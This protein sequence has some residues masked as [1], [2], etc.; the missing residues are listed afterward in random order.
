MDPKQA[1][2]HYVSGAIERGESTAIV[3]VEHVN[4]PHEPGRLYDCPGCEYQCHC[5]EGLT[6]CVFTGEHNGQADDGEET[7]GWVPQ[8]D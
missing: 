8:T 2:R 4:Y 7:H 1:L 6:Q 3:A 5:T